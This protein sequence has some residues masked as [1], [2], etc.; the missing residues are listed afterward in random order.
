MIGHLVGQE[1]HNNAVYSFTSLPL[2]VLYVKCSTVYSIDP[3]YYYYYYLDD[4]IAWS[5]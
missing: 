1:T 4:Y 5:V 3:K 2:L